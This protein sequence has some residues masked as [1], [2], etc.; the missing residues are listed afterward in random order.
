MI[1]IVG[2]KISCHMIL[3]SHYAQTKPPNR[4]ITKYKIKLES[5]HM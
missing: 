5:H 1:R 3:L 4:A 2:I